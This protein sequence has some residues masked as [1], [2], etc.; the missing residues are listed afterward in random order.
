MGIVRTVIAAFSLWSAVPMPQIPWE[1]RDLRWSLCAFPLVG[2]VVGLSWWGWAAVSGLL[3]LPDLLRGAGLCVLP[4]LV[5]GGIHLD[6]YADTWDARASHA[7][8]GRRQQILRDPHSGAF[9]VI[10]VAVYFVLDLALCAAL[11]PDGEALLCMGAAFTLSRALSGLALTVLPL[12]EGSSMA[13]ASVSA[14]DRAWSRRILTVEMLICIAFLL[15]R[16]GAAGRGMVLA[17]GAVYT[18]YARMAVQEFGGTSGDLAGWYL[19]E[20]EL[21]MLGALVVGQYLEA[22]G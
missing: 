1:E 20:A 11:R 17:A 18:R 16:G 8:P 9:A 19:Q 4:V 7:S 6:G 3:G 14:A 12:A 10:H 13:R 21:W 15:Y 2:I 22:G 5:T